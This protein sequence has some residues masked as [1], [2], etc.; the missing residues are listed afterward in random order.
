MPG[1]SRHRWIVTALALLLASW[2]MTAGHYVV[3]TAIGITILLTVLIA[4]LSRF[5][6]ILCISALGSLGMCLSGQYLANSLRPLFGLFL[7]MNWAMFIGM[8]AGHFADWALH[9]VI[10][11]VLH[12]VL[13]RVIRQNT[14]FFPLR[15]S[16][17][18][19]TFKSNS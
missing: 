12:R 5:S 17:V 2:L 3:P 13:H 16:R 19:S 1:L 9:R 11:R 7:A 15:R 8:A 18:S 14:V 6:P 4:A 10:H